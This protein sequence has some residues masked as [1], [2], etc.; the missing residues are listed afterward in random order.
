M[1]ILLGLLA[2]LPNTSPGEGVAYGLCLPSVLVL[3]DL[4]SLLIFDPFFLKC[5]LKA[6]QILSPLFLWW[7]MLAPAESAMMLTTPDSGRGLP[8]K[9]CI[10]RTL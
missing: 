8:V 6:E 9:D 5:S 10:L 2:F 4:F 7:L 1:A 3:K